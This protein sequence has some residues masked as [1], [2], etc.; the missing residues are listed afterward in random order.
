MPSFLLHGGVGEGMEALEE[1][2]GESVVAI[3]DEFA[4][5][6]GEDGGRPRIKGGERAVNDR[7]RDSAGV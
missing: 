7:L 5:L 1:L 2:R 6:D 3:E 4:A